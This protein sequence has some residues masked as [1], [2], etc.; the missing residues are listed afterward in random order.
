MPIG[1]IKAVIFDIDNT[2]LN[3]KKAFSD[4]L[5][6]AVEGLLQDG[7]SFPSHLS[8]ER[9]T[10]VE[11]QNLHF[12]DIFKE[13]FPGDTTGEPLWRVVLE[14]YREIAPGVA[15]EAT[16]NAVEVVKKFKEQGLVLGLVTNRVNMVVERMAQAGFDMNDFAFIYTPREKQYAKPHPRAFELAL[17]DLGRRG[18]RS[19]Q[20]VMFGDHT[21]D[22]YSAFYQNIN[23]V[24]VVQG[25][26]TRDGFREIGIEEN[27][28]INDLNNAEEILESV[29]KVNKYKKSLYATSAL[30]GR[31]GI[32][33]APLRHYFSEYALH[34]YRIKTEIEHVI[35]L[36]EFFNGVV[37]RL[38]TSDEKDF[39]RKLYQNF[40][41]HD[42]YEVLQYD[43]LGRN[44]MGPTEHDVKSCEL[45]IKEKMKGTSLED[46]APFVHMFV[47]SADI[48]NFAYKSMM[49]EGLRE[50]FVP[51]VLQ[52]TEKLSEL[53]KKYE[54]DPLMARTH[55]QPASPTTF[56]KIFGNYLV[57]I[58][59]G[60]ERLNSV[61]YTAK[62]N[63]AVGNYNSFMATYPDLD[64]IGYSKEL[65]S[66]F[67]FDCELWTD[68]RGPH[69]DMV[70]VLQAVQ[71]IG[72]VMRDIAQDMSLYA[73]FG[74]MYFSKVESHVGSSVMPHKINP[75][76]A[77]VAEGGIKKANWFISGFVSELDVSRLQRDLSDHEFE[78][79]YGEA[80]GYVYVAMKHLHIAFDLIRPDLEFARQEL[81][82]NPQVV[83][84]AIQTILRKHGS[85]NAYE[86]VKKESRGKHVTLEDLRS[87]VVRLDVDDVVK[88]EILTIMD[89]EKYIGLARR[90][91]KEAIEEF[92]KL[93]NS[94]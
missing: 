39:L 47:T 30:D 76:F 69:I 90:L 3:Q 64:W 75:W 77:E 33:S 2:L 66:R 1:E 71:E 19:E 51:A 24:A 56:G 28:I 62:I 6:Q 43:H 38:L 83:T 65:S 80:V 34:K 61:K 10:E 46:V 9:L 86:L 48:N 11:R 87:F 8:K 14:K 13:L 70:R 59:R 26:I 74:T 42:A 18:I 17:E 93:K 92:N 29:T 55:V 63:G 5:S 27:L 20:V 78:R 60:I 57:R 16:I 88:Q 67:G 40:S 12:E 25:H 41:E 84:E 91:A 22:Y 85:I 58:V 53:T 94:Q 31:H 7:I 52:I 36:S 68:Q 44:G 45:W 79:S 89:P 49:S 23:F 82:D 4:T 37:V 54:A 73:A 15:Y 35:T 50:E 72:N 32:M 21:D 81:R